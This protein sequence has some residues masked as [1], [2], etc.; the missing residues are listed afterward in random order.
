MLRDD[1]SGNVLRVFIQFSEEPTH[2]IAVV[3]FKAKYRNVVASFYA[4]FDHWHLQLQREDVL[5]YLVE[6]ACQIYQ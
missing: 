3:K 2:I 5:R 4:L 1:F 6:L